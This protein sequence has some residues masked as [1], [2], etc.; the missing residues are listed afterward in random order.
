MKPLSSLLGQLLFFLLASAQGILGTSSPHLPVPWL[1]SHKLLVIS[2]HLL[3]H[4]SEPM[5]RMLGKIWGGCAEN[6]ALF[7][8]MWSLEDELFLAP[9]HAEVRGVYHPSEVCLFE[10][11]AP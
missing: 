10:D 8:D 4:V 2:V 1:G 11:R 7:F 9:N 5:E 6:P 3:E